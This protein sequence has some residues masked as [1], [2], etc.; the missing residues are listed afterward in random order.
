M[1][2]E[3]KYICNFCHMT[4]FN[5]ATV[6]GATWGTGDNLYFVAK[7]KS[8][9]HLC[10][11]CIVGIATAA[12]ELPDEDP[13]ANATATNQATPPLDTTQA[14]AVSTRDNARPTNTNDGEEQ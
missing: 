8:E 2:V 9:N 5:N 6:Y 7:E 14:S 3:R 4:H 12:K 13:V 10:R 1:S 11:T